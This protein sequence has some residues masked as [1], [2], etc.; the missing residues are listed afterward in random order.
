MKCFKKEEDWDETM[1]IKEKHSSTS[2]AQ[3]ADLSL[4]LRTPHFIYQVKCLILDQIHGED[5]HY[6]FSQHVVVPTKE[7]RFQ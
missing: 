2:S 6:H 7:K 5:V 1:K 4:F 3:E